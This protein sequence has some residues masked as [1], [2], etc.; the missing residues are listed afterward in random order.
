MTGR[1][2]NFSRLERFEAMCSRPSDEDCW[3]WT[4]HVSKKG[5]ANFLWESTPKVK[6]V[7]AH[8]ASYMLYVGVIPDGMMICHHCDNRKCVNPKHL[9][10]GSAKD[11]THDMM[12]KG[13]MKY[14]F[15]EKARLTGDQ[16][17]A[18]YCDARPST[19]ICKDYG[20]TSA[21]VLCI[22]RRTTYKDV[23]AHLPHAP[24]VPRGAPGHASRRP[25]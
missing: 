7:M 10:V 25:N 5:Y 19:L 20:I 4:G 18:I 22:K 24:I 8:R 14:P 6:H 23:T 9:F 12:S 17:I 1:F 16:V 3:N 15:Q 21:H 13:R 2:K 11:N